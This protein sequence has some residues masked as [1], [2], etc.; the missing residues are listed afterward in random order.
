MRAGRQEGLFLAFCFAAASA[1]PFLPEAAQAR[2]AAYGLGAPPLLMLAISAVAGTA[3]IWSLRR[4]GFFAPAPGT[5]LG[6]ALRWATALASIMVLVDL[7]SPF[8]EGINVAWPEAWLFY[9][10]IAVAA[11][12]AL[13]LVPLAL[14]FAA[15]GRVWPSIL[16][17]ALAEPVLQT[18]LAAGLPGWQRALVAG[19]VFLIALVGLALFRRHGIAALTAL[20]VVYYLWWHLLWGAARLPLLYGGP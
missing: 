7:L 4:G 17:A 1:I 3:A 15:T 9:P 5:G 16:A 20:R 18:A 14:V 12:A 19:Q 10:A 2:F 6:T 11:E 8:P 13:H